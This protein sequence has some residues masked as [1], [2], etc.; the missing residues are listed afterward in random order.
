MKTVM[1]ITC[2]DMNCT[3]QDIIMALGVVPDVLD[4]LQKMNHHIIVIYEGVQ[5]MTFVYLVMK[6]EVLSLKFQNVVA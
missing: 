3:S 2:T 5:H 4:S 6:E 1:E